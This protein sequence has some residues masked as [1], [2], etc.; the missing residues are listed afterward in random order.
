MS[1]RL[2]LSAMKRAGIGVVDV[3]YHWVPT[4]EENVPCWSIQIT[5]ESADNLD[6]FEYHDFDNLEAV[7]KWISENV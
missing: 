4:P 3:H 5:P 7:F 2:I 6:T 1:K